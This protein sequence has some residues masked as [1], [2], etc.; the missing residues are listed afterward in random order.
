[1]CGNTSDL[2]K[3]IDRLADKFERG[4]LLASTNAA[5]FIEEVIA[6]IEELEKTINAQGDERVVAGNIVNE[7]AAKLKTT[8]DTIKW[9]ADKPCSFSYPPNSCCLNESDDENE[10]CVVCKARDTLKQIRGE[11]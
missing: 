10:W 2:T 11:T 4:H 7:L 8:E 9:I 3:A 6:R 5:A 1:M